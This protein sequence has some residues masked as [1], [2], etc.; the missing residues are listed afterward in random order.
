MS[1][2][3]LLVGMCVTLLGTSC[4]DSGLLTCANELDGTE[5]GFTLTVPEQFTCT[6]VFPNVFSIAQVRYVQSSASLVLSVQVNPP[7]TAE[8]QD[9]EGVTVEELSETTNA[10]GITFRRE[11]VTIES[12]GAF[13]YLAE[14]TLPSGNGLF[15]LLVASS[16][17]A[18]MVSTLATVVESVRFV[19]ATEQ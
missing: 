16:D 17:D 12:L 11:K 15:I 2:W 7:T 13:S 4:P 14:A 9:E 19:E 18:S 6:G 5:L 10:A 8:T 1:R 3:L